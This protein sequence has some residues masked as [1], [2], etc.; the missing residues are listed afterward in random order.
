[1]CVIS[2]LALVADGWTFV[3]SRPLWTHHFIDAAS[4]R[5]FKL[6]S[7]HLALLSRQELLMPF[8]AV[9]DTPSGGRTAT[10]TGPRHHYARYDV[11]AAA[12]EG[13]LTDPAR[14][15]L[16]DD[17]RFDEGERA[18]G[19]RW[20]NG[21]V[22]SR[23]QLLQFANLVNCFTMA[24]R[25]LLQDGSWPAANEWGRRRATKSRDLAILLSAIE[26]RYYPL[27]DEGWVRLTDCT[28]EEWDAYRASFDPIGTAQQ[29]GV[30]GRELVRTAEKLLLRAKA[31]DPLGPWSR[32]TRQAPPKYQDKVRGPSLL[33]LDMRRAAEMLLLFAEDLGDPLPARTVVAV[34]VN[35]RI[36]RHGESLESALQVVGVSPHTRVALIVEGATEVI[37][38][39][40]I[41]EYFDYGPNPDGLQVISMEGVGNKQRIQKLAAHLATPIITRTYSDSYDTLRPLCQVIVITDPEGPMTKP[42]EFHQGIVRMVTEGLK[43]QG[44]DDVDPDSFDS[45]VMVHTLGQ[46][47]EYEHFTD[48]QIAEAL[49]TLDPPPLPRGSTTDS[50][51][52]FVATA[53]AASRNLKKDLGTL[54]KT[55]LA[56]RLWLVMRDQVEAACRDQTELPPFA[57]V[58]YG[59]HSM[60]VDA[61]NRTWILSRRASRDDAGEAGCPEAPAAHPDE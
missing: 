45:L 15:P 21:L 36:S 2:T 53:R 29:L 6:R 58:V 57:D 41:L 51:A 44:V 5:G 34:P 10:S 61:M 52:Q 13:R 60:A 56:E 16:A 26:S 39:R 23:W 48:R 49:L 40:K 30:T 27:V 54:S 22:Y 12:A 28:H 33:A 59:A 38:A 7:E 1:M 37:F 11:D 47:F 42:V 24:G 18:D 17:W 14:Q 35:D 50:A 9:H 43:M 20:W 8:L 19:P 31:L 32:V 46:A 4:A 25:P 3:Q 55:R